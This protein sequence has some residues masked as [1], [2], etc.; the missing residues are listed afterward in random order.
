MQ[1]GTGDSFLVGYTKREQGWMYEGEVSNT[2]EQISAFIMKEPHS[3]ILLC[4]F[5]DQ[6]ILETSMGFVQYC[7]DQD[8]LKEKLIPALVPLQMGEEEPPKYVPLEDFGL[9]EEE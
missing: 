5:L 1:L 3:S 2:T 4:D 9:E 8:F 7:R 6:S